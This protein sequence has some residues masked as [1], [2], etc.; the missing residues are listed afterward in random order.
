[1][2]D[3]KPQNIEIGYRSL[4]VE[5]RQQDD[6]HDK[7]TR[8]PDVE[9]FLHPDEVNR[10][11][12]ELTKPRWFRLR[13][14]LSNVDELVIALRESNATITDYARELERRILAAIEITAYAQR[15]VG[16]ERARTWLMDQATRILAGERYDDIVKESYRKAQTPGLPEPLEWDAGDAGA[17]LEEFVAFIQRTM[18][19]AQERTR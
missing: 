4:F 9:G 10:R 15:C 5:T 1:M 3:D 7:E 14:R 11:L 6:T 17:L 13:S 18:A 12:A 19:S 2:G 8:W 16:I